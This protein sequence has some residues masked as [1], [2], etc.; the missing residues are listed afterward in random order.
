MIYSYRSLLNDFA[1][2]YVFGA[3]TK[4][5]NEALKGLLE[6]YLGFQIHHLQIKN[7]EMTKNIEQMKN[8][9][10]DILVDPNSHTQV[11]V[12]M[13][14]I[15]DQIELRERLTYYVARMHGIQDLKGKLYCDAKQSIVLIFANGSL[16][17]SSNFRKEIALYD[18]E[19]NLFSD[20]MKII[21]IEMN[22]IDGS[23]PIEEMSAQERMVY[24]ILNCQDHQKNSKIKELIEMDKVIHMV[25]K[26]V[27]QIEEDYWKRLNQDFAEFEENY[28]KTLKERYQQA[29]EQN[30]QREK[31]HAEEL[32]QKLHEGIQQGLDQGRQEG[33]IQTV[34]QLSK[35]MPISQIALALEISEEEVNAYLS[36]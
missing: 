33:I 7:P 32:N 5:S 26:R 10:F 1:F 25:D 23:K 17:Q 11:D 22:K 3:D 8:S 29:K 24:Y 16:F 36:K 4:D 12:E 18:E 15:V 34:K 20:S 27:N 2:K 19:G 13:Q 28:M 31:K 14:V 21:L 30:E 35:T 6:I 9:R